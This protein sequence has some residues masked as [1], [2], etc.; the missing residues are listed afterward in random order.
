L[1]EG[2]S[3]D[4][5]LA[6]RAEQELK[7]QYINKSLYGAEVVTTV[8]PSDRNRVNLNFTVV[9]GDV[10]RIKSLRIVGTKAFDESVL[11]D[12]MDLVRTQLHVVVHQI[13]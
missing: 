8:T 4:K 1:A 7:R 3:Y 10:A 2:R 9:E 5:A 12:Q 11:K 13:R 6:D